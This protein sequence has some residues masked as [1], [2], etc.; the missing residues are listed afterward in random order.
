VIP[1]CLFNFGRIEIIRVFFKAPL[2]DCS[3]ASNFLLNTCVRCHPQLQRYLMPV[4]QSF[5][6]KFAEQHA[7]V[8]GHAAELPHPKS[9]GDLGDRRHGRIRVFQRFSNLVQGSPV[10]VLHRRYPEVPEKG[11]TE[12]S[13]RHTCRSSELFHGQALAVMLFDEI[14]G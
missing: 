2:Q 14:H 1:T 5:G 6:G 12:C 8:P 9:R 13:L 11:I 3:Y 10:Q 4:P 7:V